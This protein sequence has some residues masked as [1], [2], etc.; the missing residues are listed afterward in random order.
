[1]EEIVQ[2]EIYDESDRLHRKLSALK[3]ASVL[4]LSAVQK[5]KNTAAEQ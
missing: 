5:E 3:S 2:E 4:S 1:M